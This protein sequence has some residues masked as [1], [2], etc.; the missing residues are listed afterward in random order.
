MKIYR[1][2]DVSSYQGLIDWK[3]VKAAGIEFAILKVARKDM[4]PDHQFEK[5]WAGC[6]A[7]GVPV[8]GVYHY[9]Y[10][11]DIDKAASDAAKILKILGPD[12]NPFVWLDY[13]D[14]SLPTDRRAADIINTF[15]DV[16]TEGGCEFG[17]YFGMAYYDR[18]LDKIIEYV[19][20][21]YRK[22]WEARYYNGNKKEMKI[23]DPVNME[24]TP[25]NFDG[26]RYGWQ[27]TSMG[28]VDGIDGHVDLNLWYVDIEASVDSVP[29]EKVDYH[30]S[31]FIKDSREIWGVSATARATEILSKT[32]T[33][34]MSQN[35]THAIVTPLERYMQ[36]LGYY[37]GSI[38]ADE[39]KVPVFGNGMCKAIKLYQSNVV[40][41][42]VKNQDG[43]LT[44]KGATW[45]K[46]YGAN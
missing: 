25:T 44:A 3:K 19:K 28:R 31:D 39:N 18:H 38:E 41:S 1:G 34:S 45:K 37:T 27:Y 14:K 11:A 16:I 5:N 20:P 17:V 10:A 29:E 12:R 6:L 33:V 8:Q 15:G 40:K 36:A 13:E 46:L 35:Q 4:T 21:Q 43:I 26:E 42:S 24:K 23:T 30:L 22:G 7:A 2:I 9:T 32:V